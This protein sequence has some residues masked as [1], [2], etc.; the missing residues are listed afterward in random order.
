MLT[1]D[2]LTT[3][4]IGVVLRGSVHESGNPASE[5]ARYAVPQEQGIFK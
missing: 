2:L 1:P 3:F 5:A 4:N